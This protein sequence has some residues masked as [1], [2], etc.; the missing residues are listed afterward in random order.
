MEKALICN[1]NVDP[2]TAT[3]DDLDVFEQVRFVSENLV[4]LGYEPIAVPFHTGTIRKEI[5]RI[6]WIFL[7]KKW[8]LKKVSIF[9]VKSFVK[10]N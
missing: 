5:K 1:T 3:P 6:I 9:F 7:D 10:K 8:I 2:K 4:S